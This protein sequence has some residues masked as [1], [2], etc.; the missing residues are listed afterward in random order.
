MLNILMRCKVIDFE[1]FKAEFDADDSWRRA[2]GE[3][4]FQ[5]YRDADDISMVTVMLEWDSLETGQ[6]FVDSLKFHRQLQ[7]GGVIGDPAFFFLKEIEQ[8][9]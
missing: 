4:N 6:F 7:D 2:G 9:D 8:Q 5:L 1:Q 3:H